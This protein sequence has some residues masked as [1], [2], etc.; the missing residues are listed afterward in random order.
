MMQDVVERLDI[1]AQKVRVGVLRYSSKGSANTKVVIPLGM[2][3]DKASLKAAIGA[4]A[5]TKGLTYTAQAID[6]ARTDLFKSARSDTPKVMI[7]VTDG[8][9]TVDRGRS[10]AAAV[11]AAKNDQFTMFSVGVAGAKPAE[12]DLIASDP[13]SKYSTMIANFDLLSTLTNVLVKEIC[14]TSGG[15]TGQPVTAISTTAVGTYTRSY[16]AHSTIDPSVLSSPITQTVHVVDTSGPVWTPTTL[17]DLVIEAGTTADNSAAIAASKPI[18][19]DKCSSDTPIVQF[20]VTVEPATAGSDLTKF[21]CGKTAAAGG[22]AAATVAAMVTANQ[23][24]IHFA[25][26][27][28]KYRVTWD[29]VDDA[30]NHAFVTQSVLVADTTAPVTSYTN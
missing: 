7:V 13:D 8:K 14:T 15:L 28:G 9:A 17:A 29:A 1:G 5:Y 3:T 16:V 30:G 2:H 11:T 20:V 10:L 6:K 26:A 22:Q 24:F 12:L 25:E 27:C 4:I 23:D 21:Y 18:A 19:T